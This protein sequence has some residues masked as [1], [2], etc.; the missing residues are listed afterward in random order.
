MRL[1][2]LALVL[3][4]AAP[5][6]RADEP[7]PLTEAIRLEGQL[8][9]QGALA[10]VE[11]AI[12]QGT[13]GRD[14]LVTLH[15][16]AGKL[17]AGLDR[18]SVAESHFAIALALDPT[19]NFAEGTSPKIIDPF[20]SARHKSAPLQV[21]A[22]VEAG[23]VAITADVDPLALVKGVAIR[24]GTGPG[25]SEVREPHAL[26]V[27]IPP[28]THPSEV[29]ALD[30][31]GNRVWT[32]PVIAETAHERPGGTL[33]T[34][35]RPFLARWPFWTATTVIA[36]GAGALCAWRFDSAQSE[37]D[38]LKAMGA[39]YSA[40]SDVEQRGRRWALAANISFGAAAVSGVVAI[41][42]AARGSTKTIIV[43]T[44]ESS[45]G[46]ALAGRF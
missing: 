39:E 20:E 23:A 27:A 2:V 24:L 31:Y 34:I 35:K 5:A 19:S 45:A 12:A 14:R 13:A 42:M 33:L 7:D 41:I 36:A 6:A 26:R 43:T 15:M 22:H 28:G 21:S 11:R 16:F 3:A 9:Y 18:T 37:W 46:V 10:I 25:A 17:A 38:R 29:S 1:L 32:Q 44:Q 8:D 30:A 40:L 4:V